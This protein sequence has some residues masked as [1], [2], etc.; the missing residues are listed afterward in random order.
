MLGAAWRRPAASAVGRREIEVED[1]FSAVLWYGR[2]HQMLK[3]VMLD[4]VGEGERT[5]PQ[6]PLTPPSPRPLS[7]SY[8]S[9]VCVG[10]E[11][12]IQR[13][14]HARSSAFIFL[15]LRER[16]GEES[17]RASPSCFPRQLSPSSGSVKGNR[18]TQVPLHPLRPSPIRPCGGW[19][20]LPSGDGQKA[21]CF[22]M[23]RSGLRPT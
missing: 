11:R 23:G 16:E 20:G 18:H 14:C 15:Y 13:P 12:C 2:A 19:R 17:S 6:F 1:L 7:F 5:C 4:G 10:G 8:Y 3:I 21:G 9:F 22:S